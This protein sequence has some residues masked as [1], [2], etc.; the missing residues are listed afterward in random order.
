M[1][2]FRDQ[3]DELAAVL[4]A[5]A[6]Q[7]ARVDAVVAHVAE[8]LLAGRTLFTCGNGGSAA[9][10]LHLA[11]ELVG[12]YRAD[13]RPLPAV[14]L[15]ADASALTCIANDYGYEAVFA[16]QL[17]ALARPGDVLVVF[18]TSGNSPNILHALRAARE[19]GVIGVALLG[20]DGGA[21]ALLADH[22]IIV[23]SAN[24]ARI[25]EVHGLILHA[26]CEAVEVRLLA[27]S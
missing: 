14:C 18:S 3:L 12:R 8:A 16:R 6:L 23:P 19:R 11:E 27:A 4:R 7:A 22:S 13:R 9:D 21:A 25:Q 1:A 17:T 5:F 2:Q 20:K 24:G 10:A 15:N 26:I